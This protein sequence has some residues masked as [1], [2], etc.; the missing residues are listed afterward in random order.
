[1]AERRSVQVGLMGLGVVGSGVARILTQKAES[2]ARE[3]GCPLELAR[4]LVREPGKER[5]FAVDAARLTTNAGAILDD[6]E[7]SIVIEVM[8]G[9]EPAQQYIPWLFSS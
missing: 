5:G 8:G 6:P 9:E 3:L 2:Y 1:M 7:I 4:V